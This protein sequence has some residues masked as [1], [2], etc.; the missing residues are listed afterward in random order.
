MLANGPY[1]LQSLGKRLFLVFID[2][3]SLP[4][5]KNP[6]KKRARETKKIKNIFSGAQDKMRHLFSCVIVASMLLLAL[7]LSSSSLSSGFV[8]AQSTSIPPDPNATIGSA[9]PSSTT[10]TTTTTTQATMSGEPNSTGT[11]GTAA[12]GTANPTAGGN[13]SLQAYHVAVAVAIGFL[14]AFGTCYAVCVW[15]Q[16]AVR[17][18][19]GGIETFLKEVG[20]LRRKLADEV[21]DREEQQAKLGHTNDLFER[22]KIDELSKRDAANKAE[23]LKR[24]AAD[25]GLTATD[26]SKKKKGAGG[27]SKEESAAV[28]ALNSRTQNMITFKQQRANEI[29]NLQALS[30]VGSS[31]GVVR[32]SGLFR[33]EPELRFTDKSRLP[34]SAA[35]SSRAVA[36]PVPDA[37]PK[38]DGKVDLL[39]LAL[40]E[41]LAT[42]R[43]L[44]ALKTSA[45]MRSLQTDSIL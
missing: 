28:L 12:A 16:T 22:Y 23:T 1:N 3:R 8:S 32:E 13:Q 11:N 19:E 17:D 14:L 30:R 27:A 15:Q 21:E 39:Q 9:A 6:S 2:V 31:L 10:T 26:E 35:A 41:A 40:G 34:P 45:Q 38:A 43:S 37:V 25:A 33:P 36:L 4:K 20:L 24:N 29:K 42:Q 18:Y 44:H 5:C 7:A